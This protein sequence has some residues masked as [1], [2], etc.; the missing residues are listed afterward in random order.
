M[1]CQLQTVVEAAPAMMDAVLPAAGL[2]SS[3]CSSAEDV[4]TAS[5]AVWVATAAALSGFC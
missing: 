1:I 3:C 5:V 2:S 4:E